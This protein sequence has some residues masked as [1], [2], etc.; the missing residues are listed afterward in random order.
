MLTLYDY[1]PSQ[2]AWKVRQVLHEL[3]QAYRTEEV[4]IFEGHGQSD[5][6]RK[7]NPWGAVP[8]IRLED[9]R[10][11][12]ESNAIL[13]YLAQGSRLVPTDGFDQ[14][15]V[16]QWMSFEAD[17]VQTSLGSLRYWLLTGKI[18]ARDPSLVEGKRATGL[19][20]LAILDHQ[21]AQIPFVAGDYSIAD[22]SLF[23]YASRAEEAGVSLEAFPNFRAWIARVASRPAGM[24]PSWPYSIDPHAVAELP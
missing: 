5:G 3:R 14:A 22:I 24:A 16:L 1:R 17:Y 11:L 23:A 8:A 18:G 19:R 2:N 4:S 15:K 21:V 9:G 6:F 7:I 20:A 10:V 13:W 12:S